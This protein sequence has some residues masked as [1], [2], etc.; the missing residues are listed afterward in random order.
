MGV[1]ALLVHASLWSAIKNGLHYIAHHT[2]I[3]VVLV[4]ALGVVLSWRLLKKAT[5][6]AVEVAVV[7]VVLLTA[8]K[9]GWISW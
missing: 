7:L 2:G 4:A 9:L 8:T 1:A 6:L 5:R 3:P